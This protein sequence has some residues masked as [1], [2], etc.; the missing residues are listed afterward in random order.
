MATCPLARVRTGFATPFL[1]RR[2][3][4]RSA[5]SE[6][7]SIINIRL[8]MSTP[9]Y[10][11]SQTGQGLCSRSPPTAMG[12]R[13]QSLMNP[14]PQIEACLPERLGPILRGSN[15]L[16]AFA[17]TNLWE[18]VL[19]NLILIVDDQEV[20][21]FTL[22]RTLRSIGVRNPIRRLSDGQSAI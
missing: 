20:D 4:R 16:L 11:R 3:S 21:Q 15:S 8:G 1:R 7:S 13:A 22:E 17:C 12:G 5:S 14:L 19:G 6:L 2:S 18:I 10:A 9:A